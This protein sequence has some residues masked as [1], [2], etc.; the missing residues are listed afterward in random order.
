MIAPSGGFLPAGS[1]WRE[2]RVGVHIPA[3]AISELRLEEKRFSG[4]YLIADLTERRDVIEN[5]ERPAVSS[6]DDVI[7][8]DYQIANRAR[9]HI[10]SQRLPV[11][12]VVER[13]VDG[14]LGPAE[15]QAR[16]EPDPRE[17]H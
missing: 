1:S 17:R 7:V 9:R 2:R 8:F 13:D 14:A 12:A 10:Q 4:G 5:P 3:D 15:E 6:D 11:V 16:V